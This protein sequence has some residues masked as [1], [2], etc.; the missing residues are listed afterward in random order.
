MRSSS[1]ANRLP[2]CIWFLSDPEAFGVT[3]QFRRDHRW[4]LRLLSATLGWGNLRDARRQ[5]SSGLRPH[6]IRC[7]PASDHHAELTGQKQL[8]LRSAV[9]PSQRNTRD[10]QAL[11]L[12]L[13]YLGSDYTCDSNETTR[14]GYKRTTFEREGSA[15]LVVAL[16]SSLGLTA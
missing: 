16:R 11:D 10:G 14:R 15:V 9:L 1:D 5:C 6:A 13:R 7:L 3:A 2:L 12:L 8:T 4:R